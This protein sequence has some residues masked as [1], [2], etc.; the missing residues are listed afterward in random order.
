[1]KIHNLLK[2]TKQNYSSFFV[3]GVVVLNKT[4]ISTRI[5]NDCQ[6]VIGLNVSIAGTKHEFQSNI[7]GYVN[8][9]IKRNA[10]ANAPKSVMTVFI[11]IF[12]NLQILYNQN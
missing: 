5:P 6:N 10:N 11:K 2:Y 4:F 8:N 12:I 3:L 7:T 1:M 9:N